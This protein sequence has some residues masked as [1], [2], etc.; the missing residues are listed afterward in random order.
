[1]WCLTV[2]KRRQFSGAAQPPRAYESVAVE[3]ILRHGLAK[4]PTWAAFTI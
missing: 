4:Q 3:L 1:M 2:T